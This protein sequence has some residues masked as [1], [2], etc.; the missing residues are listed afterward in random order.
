[1]VLI[2]FRTF[3]LKPNVNFSTVSSFGRWLM[4]NS[5]TLSTMLAQ[6]SI[7]K[8]MII[9]IIIVILDVIKLEPKSH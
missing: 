5:V 8:I 7:C 2:C 6:A 4:T 3:V 9:I 1:M